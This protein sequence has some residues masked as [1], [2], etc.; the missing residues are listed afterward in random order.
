MRVGPAQQDADDGIALLIGDQSADSLPGSRP[1]K[2]GDECE[3]LHAAHANCPNKLLARHCL[4]ETHDRDSV[5]ARIITGIRRRALETEDLPGVHPDAIAKYLLVDLVSMAGEHGTI[6]P[7][8]AQ[9]LSI[10]GV[11][12][13]RDFA[14]IDLEFGILTVHCQILKLSSRESMDREPVTITIPEYAVYLEAG[15]THYA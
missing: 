5:I 13:D 1:G 14:L 10:E 6:V 2:K 11:M 12:G 7:R 8:P 15:F 4:L 3:H 9:R